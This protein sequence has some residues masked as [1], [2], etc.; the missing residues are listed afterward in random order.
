MAAAAA[1]AA[2]IRPQDGPRLIEAE[3]DEMVYEII[4]ELPDTGLLPG[5]VPDVPN[6][7]IA[8]PNNDPIPATSPRQ[9]PT[10]S[11]R[12]VVGNQPY[13]TYAPRMQF[14]QLGEVQAHRSALSAAQERQEQ[15]E[16]PTN[17]ALMHA[18]IIGL[19]DLIYLWAYWPNCDC[20]CLAAADGLIGL[21]GPVG[22]VSLVDRNGLVGCPGSNGLISLVGCCIIGLID[23]SDLLNPPLISLIGF[24]HIG[25]YASS[26]SVGHVGLISLNEIIGLLGHIGLVNQ[27]DLVEFNGLVGHN[28]LVNCIGLPFIG[29][30]GPNDRVD[31]NGLVSFI[32]LGLIGFISMGL[33]SLIG[34]IDHISRIGLSG[35]YSLKDPP[36]FEPRLAE[37]ESAV[38]TNYTMQPTD[39]QWQAYTT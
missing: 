28:N 35:F 39:I 15:R 24:S 17:K 4:A 9:Y 13:N 25:L 1:A 11:R 26:A 18:T 34:L 22:Q 29:L 8:P 31:H 7:S 37:A 16:L 19:I 30:F 2:P 6:E 14:W 27:N 10:R 38:I 32:G 21:N 23:L 20:D 36:D 12:S 3:P 5:L 33:V